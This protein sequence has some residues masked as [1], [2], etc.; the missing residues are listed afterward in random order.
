MRPWHYAVSLALSVAPALVLLALFRRLDRGRSASRRALHLSALLG[1][2]AC[3]PAALIEGVAHGTLGEA[4][5]LG[6]RFLDAFLVAALTE[7]ALKLCVVWALRRTAVVTVLDGVLHTVAVGL[8]F[9]L[10]ENLGYSATD[11]DTALARALTA[12][13]LHAIA[14]GVMGYFVGRARF[15]RPNS[16]GPLRL[17][18]LCCAVLI[19]GTYDWAVYNRG[20]AGVA[21][22]TAV[23]L[24]G[25]AVLAGLVRH[26]RRLDDAM[27]G[28]PSLP[29]APPAWPTDVT[30]TLIPA[31]TLPQ[32]EERSG[33]S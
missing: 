28:R 5:L 14:A 9:G 16:A 32:P 26:A 4:S 20:F 31:D 3:V 7:E 30:Q 13:P 6:S 2:L 22:A 24:L 25:G 15:V 11:V 27:L 33:E 1:A 10:L 18:G 12:V 23:L 17:T 21:P 19:H 8:G 29:T